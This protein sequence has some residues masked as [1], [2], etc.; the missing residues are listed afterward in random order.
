MNARPAPFERPGAFKWGRRFFTGFPGVCSSAGDQN[1]ARRNKP[2]SPVLTRAFFSPAGPSFWGLINPQWMLCNKGRRQSPIDIDPAKMLFDPNL[3][4]LSVDKH[5]VDFRRLLHPLSRQNRTTRV[6]SRLF[7]ASRASR[8]RNRLR[9][10]ERAPLFERNE[11]SKRDAP[12]GADGGAQ[13]AAF[14]GRLP[15]PAL[16]VNIPRKYPLFGTTRG[17][18]LS[19]RVVAFECAQQKAR[20]AQV[21]ILNHCAER[22]SMEAAI[23]R[24]SE[25]HVRPFESMRAPTTLSLCLSRPAEISIEFGAASNGAP[26]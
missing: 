20:G 23:D 9:C 15:R 6:K 12:A 18:E 22:K 8:G 25:R 1:V 2:L 11:T 7:R 4:P 10:E 16:R 5:K 26:R 3:R 21:A 17:V 14:G 13:L 24:K 19:K